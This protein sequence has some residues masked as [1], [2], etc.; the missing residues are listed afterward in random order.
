MVADVPLGAFLSGGIDSSTVVALMQAQS[1]RPVR[2][3][4]I[5]FDEARITMRRRTH[6]R[7]PGISAPNIPSFVSP[8]RRRWPSYRICR[9]SGTSRSPTSRRSRPCFYRA[10]RASTSPSRYL[11]TAETK[12]FGGYARHFMS[13]SVRRLPSACR[14]RRPGG[15]MLGLTEPMERISAGFRF[16]GAAPF[17]RP[18]RSWKSSLRALEAPDERERYEQLIRGSRSRPR[19]RAVADPDAPTPPMPISQAP[20]LSR[21]GRLSA[22][23]YP[24]QARPRDH[25]GRPGGTLSV[26]RPPRRRVRLAACRPRRRSA[27]ERASGRCGACS[28][29]YLPETLF[30]RPK[31]GFNVPIGAWLR[32][33][34]RDWAEELLARR[35][36]A[37]K[38][39]WIQRACKPAGSSISVAGATAARAVGRSDGPG[40][41]RSSGNPSSGSTPPRLAERDAALRDSA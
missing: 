5:G 2:T 14:R 40:L 32:G 17:A 27:T 11:A 29:R 33:P 20:H 12:C 39:C 28:R 16:R 4:T 22:R 10:W 6:R 35:S 26:S 36:S 21:H 1:S 19:C 41:A 3:F 38:V 18:R 7:W 15:G 34:L 30:E 25:G 23:R 31:Q 13:G 8:R 9:G 37:G 24:G